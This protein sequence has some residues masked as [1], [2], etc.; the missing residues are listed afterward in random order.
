MSNANA[1]AFGTQALDHQQ[2]ASNNLMY[3]ASEVEVLLIK[4]SILLCLA[5]MY[6]MRF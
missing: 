6:I 3:T 2:K 1:R 5:K 4:H